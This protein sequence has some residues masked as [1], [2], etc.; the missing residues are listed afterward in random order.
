MLWKGST[1]VGFGVHGK[2]VIAW[3]CASKAEL[4]DAARA[5]VNIGAPCYGGG[6]NKCYNGLALKYA[7]KLRNNHDVAPLKLNEAAARELEYH[8]SAQRPG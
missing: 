6:Y 1:K 4:A 3:Y 7:N 2:Y 8:L 5:K